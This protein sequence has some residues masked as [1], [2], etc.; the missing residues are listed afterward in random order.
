MHFDFSLRKDP[1]IWAVRFP[2]HARKP[3]LWARPPIFNDPNHQSA[4]PYVLLRHPLP[5]PLAARAMNWNTD[6]TWCSWRLS[7][8]PSDTSCIEVSIGVIALRFAL[9]H[10][11]RLIRL[12]RSYDVEHELTNSAATSNVGGYLIACGC[13]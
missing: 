12:F 7:H 5:G 10:C 1:A 11:A 6:G 3:R 2:Q 9:V 13:G 4:S 8:P